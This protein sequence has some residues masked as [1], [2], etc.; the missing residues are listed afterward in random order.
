[1]C[2]TPHN[3]AEVSALEYFPPAALRNYVTGSGAILIGSEALSGAGLLVTAFYTSQLDKKVDCST[4]AL[5]VHSRSPYF[6]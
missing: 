5:Y 6:I 2:M 1:M 4:H 3:L